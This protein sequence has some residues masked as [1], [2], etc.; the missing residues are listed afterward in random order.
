M[1]MTLTQAV[2]TTPDLQAVIEEA[3]KRIPPLWPLEHFVAVNPFLGLTDRPFAEACATLRRTLGQA[4]VQ[5][6][7]TYLT[8]WNSGAITSADLAPFTDETWTE[9]RLVDALRRSETGPSNRPVV[10]FADILDETVVHAHWSR[11]VAEEVA[12]WCAVHFDCNQT[13]WV[14]PW[15]QLGLFD[16]WKSSAV[17]DRKPEAFG[18]PGFREFVR[19]LPDEPDAAIRFCLGQ[20][21][22]VG[23]DTADFLHRQLASVSG[24]AGHAQYLVREDALRGRQNR[25]LRELLAIRLA[26]DAALHSAFG[27]ETKVA[28]AWRHQCVTLETTELDEALARWQGAYEAGYQQKLVADLVARS[29]GS[30]VA[31]PMVQAIFCIDVR[32]E[33]VRRHLEAALPGTLT[34]GF[35][36]FFG[37]PVAH[38]T[39]YGDKSAS[40][41]PALLAPPVRSRERASANSDQ[42][43][44]RKGAW[45]AFQN[46]ATSCFTFVESLGLAF[47]PKLI[48]SHDKRHACTAPKPELLDLPVAARAQLAEGALRGM[49]LTKNFARLVLLC[50]HGS[51]SANNPYASSLDCGACG[52]H[53]GDV[54]ARLAAATLNDPEVRAELAEHGIAIPDDTLFLSGRHDTLGDDFVLYDTESIPATHREEVAAL[55]V[56]LKVAGAAARRERAPRLGLSHLNSQDLARAISDRGTDIAQVRPEW[57]LANNAALI[58][59]PRTRTAKLTL[60]GRVFLH[61]YQPLDDPESKILT[62]ILT[63]PVVVASWINLQYYAS[64]IDPD[65]WAAGNKT[66]H[67][68][69]AGIGVIEG[70]AGDL[71]TGLPLQSI[72][73]GEKFAHEPRRLTVVIES[74]TD[75][76][77]AV[78]QSHPEVC[79]LFDHQWLHLFALTE[80]GAA[81][82]RMPGGGWK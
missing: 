60:D 59:A 26:Y 6:A 23:I 69:V 44:A 36:G 61:E 47:A 25:A 10:S 28:A 3:L 46:S 21:E 63:A 50:G 67:Q 71:K 27:T 5:A 34:L 2:A 18:L 73:D 42:V 40:R 41:C 62:A 7:D 12:K 49:S 65:R 57:A 52:G 17:Y 39:A 77:D 55:E 64:R 45:R 80:D 13:T 16:A 51:H 37:F 76:I 1:N 79:Q 4:P 30:V 32:S 38:Q 56:A 78:L 31:R 70:N 75:R 54:N 82:R 22:P 14:S 72:H 58:A 29:V 9:A 53:A 20:L 35:A 68:V 43:R 8:A 24:W 11:F 66:I 15:R 74:E 33:I 81:C 48:R 19:A